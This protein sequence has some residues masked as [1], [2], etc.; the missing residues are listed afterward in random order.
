MSNGMSFIN[1]RWVFTGGP[2]RYKK[3]P[4]EDG[5]FTV[6]SWNAAGESSVY[7]GRNISEADADA[8]IAR[9][10]AGRS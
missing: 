10:S 1:N 5:T 2:D 8:M 9:L 3:R 7:G 4:N 6:V